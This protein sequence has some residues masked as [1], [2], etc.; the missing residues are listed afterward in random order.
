MEESTEAKEAKKRRIM[1][2]DDHEVGSQVTGGYSDGS[3][4]HLME[5]EIRPI[6]K[7]V[8]QLLGRVE[9]G[10]ASA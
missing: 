5:G 10:T 9:D 4:A 6:S 8:T 3:Q 1:G 2:H 7:V